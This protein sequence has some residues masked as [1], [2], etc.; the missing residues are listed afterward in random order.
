MTPI[1]L[2][3]R[4]LWLCGSKVADH[5]ACAAPNYDGLA[6]FPGVACE[7]KRVVAGHAGGRFDED[8]DEPPAISGERIHTI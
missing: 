8:L 3:L 1:E 4:V 5:K 2:R 7:D 6:A